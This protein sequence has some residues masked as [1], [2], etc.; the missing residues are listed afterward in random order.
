MADRSIL[1]EI[2]RLFEWVGELALAAGEAVPPLAWKVGAVVLGV[3]AVAGYAHWRYGSVREWLARWVLRGIGSPQRSARRLRYLVVLVAVAGLVSVVW[4]IA[5]WRID[6]QAE[7]GPILR[8][9]ARLLTNWYLYVAVMALAVAAVR[10]LYWDRLAAVTATHTAY[11]K[12]AIKRW[13]SEVLSTDGTVRLIGVESDPVDHLKARLLRATSPETDLDDDLPAVGESAES[14]S[15]DGELGTAVAG[16]LTTGWDDAR[17]DIEDASATA[18]H[19]AGELEAA[20]YPVRRRSTAEREL[21]RAASDDTSTFTTT[22]PDDPS[23][24]ADATATEPAPDGDKADLTAR[25][26]LSQTVQTFVLDFATA[27]NADDIIW[28]FLLPAATAAYLS[29]LFLQRVF[30]HPLV[31]LGIAGASIL[32]GALFY[33]GVKWRRRRRLQKARRS[34]T[35]SG[36]GPTACLVKRVHMDREGVPDAYVAF[37]GGHVYFSFDRGSFCS[38]VAE[39][40]RQRIT[41]QDVDPAIE[42]KFARDA[43]Q[44]LPMTHQIEY[45]DPIEGRPAVADAIAEAIREGSTVEGVIP[46][47]ILGKRVVDQGGSLGHDPDL[48]REEYQRG[49]GTAWGESTIHLENRHGERVP[50]TIV[51]LRNRG[52]LVDLAEIRATFAQEFDPDAEPKYPLPEVPVE[53]PR[54]DIEHGSLPPVVDTDDAD[55]FKGRGTAYSAD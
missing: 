31:Y 29:F 54:W 35:Q 40:W 5:N 51:Y 53:T 30:F 1:Y 43:K 55:P 12:R 33:H 32:F 15:V 42:E 52:V 34:P 20:G 41:K 2:L 17:A 24:G 48:V 7:S 22:G 11:S 21:Q 27:A 50:M 9:I 44:M 45:T 47:H 28:R 18:E 16:A 8:G 39:R 23:P 19:V 14:E 10:A 37:M 25:Q 26:H 38:K 46:K 3:L 6:I 36:S 4:A 13:H 49:A